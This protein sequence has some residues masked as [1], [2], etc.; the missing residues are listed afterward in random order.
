M[1]SDKMK[2]N[3]YGKYQSA[4][5]RDK[6]RD[7]WTGDGNPNYGKALSKETRDKISET[8]RLQYESGELV[9]W[10]KGKKRKEVECPHCNKTG[11]NGIMQRWHFDNCKLKNN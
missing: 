9:S 7:K 11:G 8:K 10:N 3:D 5:T 4:E 6:K 2:G 1:I